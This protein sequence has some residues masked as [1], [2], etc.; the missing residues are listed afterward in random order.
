MQVTQRGDFALIGNTLA[1]DCS[2]ATPAPLVGTVGS[3]GTQTG[4]PSPDVFWTTDAG[5]ATASDTITSAAARSTAV[6][7]LPAGA[8]VTHA[9][10]YWAAIRTA[11]DD[12]VTLVR[13]DGSSGDVTAVSFWVA[14][15]DVYQ[16]VA[17]VTAIVRAHGAGAY[18]VG[19]VGSREIANVASPTAFAGWWMVVLHRVEGA[20][21]RHLAVLDGLAPVSSG[22]R[23]IS[24]L[25]GLRPRPA[26]SPVR[27]GAV[28][29]GG[30]AVY[31][32]DQLLFQNV[33]VFDA[34]NPFDNFFNGTRSTSGAPTSSSGDLPRLSGAAASMSGMDIDVVDVLAPLPPGATSATIEARA[35]SDVLHLA[36][37]V[38]SIAASGPDFSGATLTVT[39]LD[40]G[41]VLPGD[42]LEHTIA[43]VNRGD[44]ASTGTELRYVLPPELDYEP[45]SLVV[46]A[47]PATDAGGDD[48]AEYDPASR[49]IVARLGA[50]AN[51]AQGGSLA[52]TEPVAV[53][54]RARP[55][56]R[57][58]LTL[59]AT[60][61][62]V[63]AGGDTPTDGD[64]LVD[65]AQPTTLVVDACAD[66]TR[67]AAPTPYCDLASSPTACVECT[68]DAHCPGLAPT[69][70]AGACACVASGAEVCNGRDDDCDGAIDQDDP[71]GGEACESSLPGACSAG[72]TACTE[73][74]LVCVAVI[75]PGETTESCNGIDDDCDDAIDEAVCA[76]DASID[77]DAGRP[78]AAAAGD[79]G[80]DTGAGDAG[81]SCRAAG[82]PRGGA[83]A[84]LVALLAIALAL[85][86]RRRR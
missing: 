5:G 49:T 13:P 50:G 7:D 29:Y 23:R 15:P 65:G 43:I 79:A 28:T 37:F 55:S 78:D 48:A 77:V 20:P 85:R 17:D 80:H 6:L 45:G 32:G 57:A 44:G 51:A 46:G 38:A 60:I 75:A 86:S 2:P 52:P 27:L 83:H 3:C 81:C 61:F 24:M 4:D 47:G 54:L 12:T 84:A 73:G 33:P 16:G 25:S 10:L 66:D 21:L 39:D 72:A 31:T 30:D 42:E 67:C 8:V 36:G 58:T 19:D 40:G 22:I 70:S 41:R 63:D 76:A 68:T 82:A 14:P 53:T 69:C 64:P 62:A 71:G 35:T 59:Q 18:T 9:Y 56:Q 34:Q 1:H 11:P 74:E 26:G